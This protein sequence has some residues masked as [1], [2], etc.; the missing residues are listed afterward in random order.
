[1]YDASSS[2]ITVDR[3]DVVTP[4][5]PQMSGRCAAAAIIG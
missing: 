5:Y 2:S 1:M 3:G 4:C